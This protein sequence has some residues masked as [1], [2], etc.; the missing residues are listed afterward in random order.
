MGRFLENCLAAMF[1]PLSMEKLVSIFIF[2]KIIN[3]GEPE[4]LL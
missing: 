2:K 1:V 3:K 4:G